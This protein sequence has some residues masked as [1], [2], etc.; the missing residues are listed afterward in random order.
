M[1]I[2][3]GKSKGKSVQKRVSAKMSN[4]GTEGTN[5]WISITH[6]NRV[7]SAHTVNRADLDFECEDNK[8]SG[9]CTNWRGITRYN[10]HSQNSMKIAVSVNY[11]RL[12]GLV[13]SQWVA[14]TQ[15]ERNLLSQLHLN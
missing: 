8:G 6:A 11:K 13:Q 7:H 1:A 5:W 4:L 2:L 9:Q 3:Q 12:E 10:V 14:N 15:R